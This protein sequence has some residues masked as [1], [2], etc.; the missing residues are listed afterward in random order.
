[1]TWDMSRVVGHNARARRTEIGMEIA[2]FGTRMEEALGRPWKRQTVSAMENGDRAMTANDL[3]AVAHVLET[4][5]SLLL[6]P[7]LAAKAV[8]VGNLIVDRQLLLGIPASLAG[9]TDATLALLRDLMDEV[10]HAWA[11]AGRAQEILTAEVADRLKSIDDRIAVHVS[12][13]EKGTSDG[14]GN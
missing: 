5:P 12:G 6:V 10:R 3:V 1:M 11:A 14:E 7:P 4:T 13:G 2:T 8:Q 9:S